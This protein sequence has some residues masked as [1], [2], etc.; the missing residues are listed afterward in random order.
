MPS[1]MI[2]TLAVLPP[3]VRLLIVNEACYSGTLDTIAPDIGAQRDVLVETAATLGEQS[4]S[5]KS[6]SG[7]NRCTL[8]GAAFVEDYHSP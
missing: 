4:W 2:G 8:F 3:N 5:Y 7:R 1:N 6:G